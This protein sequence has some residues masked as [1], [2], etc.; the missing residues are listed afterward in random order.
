MGLVGLGGAGPLGG[1]GLFGAGVHGERVAL[2]HRDPVTG[3]SQ[4]E[5]RRQA[6]DAPAGD[7]H[8]F[9]TCHPRL[10]PWQRS[11]PGL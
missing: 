3:P 4:G 1:E 6:A 2:E 5:R 9:A 10:P 7:H 8:S 11:L